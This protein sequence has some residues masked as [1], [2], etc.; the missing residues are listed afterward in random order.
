MTT[1]KTIVLTRWTFVGKVMSLVF[2]MQSRLVIAF[3]PRRKCLL[4]SWLLSPSAVILNHWCLRIILYTS[5]SFKNQHFLFTCVHLH[6]GIYL[7]M[8]SNFS[9]LDLHLLWIMA[10]LIY[11][12][13]SFAS[14]SIFY[15]NG[16]YLYISYFNFFYMSL[17]AMLAYI[18]LKL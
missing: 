8:D 18:H 6:L 1:G 14:L 4:I 17:K 3:L 13:F 11:S 7:Y 10:F 5:F 16:I 15:I 12:L 9:T 2:N